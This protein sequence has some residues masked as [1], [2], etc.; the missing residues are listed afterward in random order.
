MDKEKIRQFITT[1]RQAGI[2]DADI[3]A[4]L[5]QK[6]AI[7]M[8]AQTTQ[9]QDKTDARYEKMG[10]IG[11]TL[12]SIFGGNKVGEGIGTLAARQQAN[13]GDMEIADY[14]SLSPQAIERLRAK[15]VPITEEEQRAEVAKGIE[16]PSAKE[17]AGDVAQIGL[18][19]V[20]AGGAKALKGASLVKKVATGAGIGYL[21]DV[22][23]GL[24]DGETI[25]ESAV[26]GVGAIVGGAIP[27]VGAATRGIGRAT[28]KIGTTA[29][30]SVIPTSS[31]E[32]GIL[33]TYKANNPFLKRVGDVLKGTEK[34][35]TT[36]GKTVAT[37]GLMGTKSQIGVQ[38]K[39]AEQKLWNDV[40]SPRLKGSTKAVDMDGFFNKIQEDIVTSTPE[41]SRQKSLLNALESFK[42]DYAGVKSVSLD[43]LQKLK[44]GWAEFIPEKAYRGEN[45]SGAAN[46]VRNLLANESRQTIYSQLGDEVKQAYFD[47]GNLQGLKKMGQVSMTG[48][49]LKGGT[50][51][52]VSEI[53][54]QTV[55][56]IGTVGGQA[57][58]KIGKGIEFIGNLG[59]KN[60][61]EALG[62]KSVSSQRLRKPAKL[63]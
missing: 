2:P 29:I 49:K 34:A 55:T 40:I 27:V 26:P 17:L 36:A 63:K 9:S 22:S 21:Y 60:L 16:G 50:G 28:A 47:Y 46:Q 44:E 41:A 57:I 42:E 4:F 24:K 18:N 12:G 33:Q 10:K 6:G 35:P 7:Q 45:I 14:S 20:G 19:F 52:L 61:G 53:F 13:T 58:Y 43:K 23:T 32:A 48:Q 30:E 51:G 8:P 54:S 37:K 39:R 5:V 31:R 3:H 25:G 59:A 62:V 15:G 56:P 38:A 1:Q 11:N